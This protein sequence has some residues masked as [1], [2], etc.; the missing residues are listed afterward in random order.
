MIACALVGLDEISNSI[1][2]QDSTNHSRFCSL[3]SASAGSAGTRF[4]CSKVSSANIATSSLIFPCSV[5]STSW[6]RARS[7]S[8]SAASA[9][10]FAAS[11]SICAF[12][13]AS[14]RLCSLRSRSSSAVV[15]CSSARIAAHSCCLP[16]SFSRSP[17]SSAACCSILACRS[18]CGASARRQPMRVSAAKR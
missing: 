1:F 7:R 14:S 4:S 18:F 3:A 12:C 15:T 2:I 11:S 5:S 16:V 9:S 13:V 17:L 8:A 10:A 6:A